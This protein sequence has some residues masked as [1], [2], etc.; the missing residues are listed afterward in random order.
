MRVERKGK[1]LGKAVILPDR[2]VVAGQ[3]YAWDI[4]YTAGAKGIDCGGTIR[5][6]IPYGFTP[7][8][9]AYPSAIGYTTVS[10][11]NSSTTPTIH[12]VDPKTGAQR[13][14]CWG[15]YLYVQ[16][17][18]VALPPG[19]TITVHYGKGHE[20]RLT[21]EGAFAQYFEGRAEF[22]VLVD[23]DGSRAAPAGGFELIDDPQPTLYVVGGKASHLFVCVPSVVRPGEP[24]PVKLTARDQLDN[25]AQDFDEAITVTTPGH[26]E[27]RQ[28]LAVPGGRGETAL[29]VD[30]ANGTIVV[31][32]QTAA[33]AVRGVSNPCRIGE[34]S[35][36]LN[37]YWGD[38]HV[39]TEVSA[40]LARPAEAYQYARDFSHLD[41]CAVTDG[42]KADGYFTDEEWEE[43]RDAVKHFYEP[44]RFVTLPA[45][46]YHERKKAG[47]KNIYYRDDQ[48]ELIR[49]CD[50]KGEQ[51]Q[52]LWEALAGRKALTI[53]H[54]TVSGSGAM[55]VWDYYH[56]DY[57]RL[58]EVYSCWGN[59]EAEDCILQNY[60]G[61]NFRNSVQAGLAKG[62]RMGIIASGDSHDGLAGNSSWMRLRRGYRNGLAAVYA[63]EL[64][65]EAVFDA[66]WDRRCYGTSGTRILLDVSL[67]GACMGRELSDP[68]HRAERVLRVEVVGTAPLARVE[69]VRNGHDAHVQEGAGREALIEWTD[70]DPFDDVCLTGVDGVP[71]VYYYVRVTQ[72]DRELAWSSPIWIL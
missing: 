16:I 47:D 68:K 32:A 48:E 55:P 44:Y 24:L 54:H 15:L 12:L 2:A 39:M 38:L 9:T 35:D 7:P 45:S 51:P 43:T 31:S 70:T 69:I 37:V 3:P 33:G 4:V 30:T 42:D 67:N 27:H 5:F 13:Q 8:Q 25:T 50:L 65:R 6:D 58:V 26:N 28:T 49:W 1:D 18:G 34:R 11:S 72:Q 22:S 23:A 19:E 10:A 59:S 60:W 40:G 41:F 56:P 71:F 62:Y 64:T 53:P 57:Q 29:S 21:G 52:A 36:G 46:E 14:G 17:E 61:S 20:G 66:L 63:P